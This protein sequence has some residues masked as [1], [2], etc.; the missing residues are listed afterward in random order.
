MV[1]ESQILTKIETTITK[2]VMAETTTKTENQ[3]TITNLGINPTKTVMAGTIKVEEDVKT[4]QQSMT[5]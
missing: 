1:T 3:I 2:T 4:L 5:Q